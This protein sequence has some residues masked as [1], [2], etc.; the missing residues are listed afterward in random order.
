MT[1]KRLTIKSTV[2]LITKKLDAGKAED[3]QVFDIRSISTL[4]D[5]TVIATGTSSRHVMSLAHHLVEELKKH[6]IRPMND[7]HQGE[8]HWVVVDLGSI[9]VHIFTQD[10]RL[11]YA[12]EE[13]WQLPKSKRSRKAPRKSA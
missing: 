8:G 1:P 9:L 4:A 2:N 3:I 7:I 13:I 10:T 6:D 11:T 12:L 5:Y